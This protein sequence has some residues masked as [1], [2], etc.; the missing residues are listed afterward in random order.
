M[1]QI[2][3]VYL[4]LRLAEESG[5]TITPDEGSGLFRDISKML[6]LGLTAKYGLEGLMKVGFAEKYQNGSPSLVFITCYGI[7]MVL[8][9]YFKMLAKGSN[10]TVEE[11]KTTFKSAKVQAEQIALKLN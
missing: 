10:L 4:T 3:E 1:L 5:Q 11:M 7:G 2:S 9:H 6:G 8:A